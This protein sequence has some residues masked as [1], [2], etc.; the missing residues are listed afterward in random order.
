MNQ[1]IDQTSVE[2]ST[3]APVR[4]RIWALEPESKLAMARST[5]VPNRIV[6]FEDNY[7]LVDCSG[8]R[9]Q[10]SPTFVVLGLAIIST[11]GYLLWTGHI[12]F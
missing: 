7:G 5:D 10:T 1:S 11:L 9:P 6:F 4:T 2:T 12:K 3:M 8:V